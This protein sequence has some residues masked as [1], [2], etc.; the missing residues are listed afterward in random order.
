M[1]PDG[2]WGHEPWRRENGWLIE[3]G[4]TIAL[5]AAIDEL[6]DKPDSI[7]NCGKAAMETAC[8]RPWEMYGNELA[9]AILNDD[10]G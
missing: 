7:I 2:S 8:A 3:A 6:L 9:Q 10:N 1:L 5:I 4:S